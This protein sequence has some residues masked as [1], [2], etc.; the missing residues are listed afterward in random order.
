MC[1]TAG[2]V[3]TGRWP[4]DSPAR[5]GFRA[6][7]PTRCS[8]APSAVM[9]LLEPPRLAQGAAVA[10]PAARSGR[11]RGPQPRRR[12]PTSHGRPNAGR[13]SRAAACPGP[14]WRAGPR[15]PGARPPRAPPS[16]GACGA[17]RTCSTASATRCTASAAGGRDAP[18]RTIRAAAL[19]GV[20]GLVR[21]DAEVP[22]GVG[23]FLPGRQRVRPC[24]VRRRLRPCAPEP[25]RPGSAAATASATA[26][27]P[28]AASEHPASSP[29]THRTTSRAVVVLARR[30][31]RGLAGAPT[32]QLAAAPPC[33]SRSPRPSRTARRTPPGRHVRV[34]DGAAGRLGL[35][36]R[37]APC[38]GS[39]SARSGSSR[40]PRSTARARRARP[41]SPTDTVPS[42]CGVPGVK[43]TA[44]RAGMPSVRAIAA[45]AKEKW[46]QKPSL[47]RRNRAIASEPRADLHLGVVP[48]AA[49]S[50]RT[51]PGA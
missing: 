23:Q 8:A 22:G 42:G 48:E 41:C 18:S 44:T 17:Y 9:P 34:R 13:T 2:G 7:P 45:I 51:S 37:R 5:P 1:W 25:H 24:R 3:T 33:S 47:S 28:A 6:S 50:P 38:P 32:V 29:S 12:G 40:R 35:R 4:A 21:A 15:S 30:G 10:A 11:Q 31:L 36:V 19:R 27:A 16:G 46:T 26:G 20:C 43:P 14:P 49:A 39:G